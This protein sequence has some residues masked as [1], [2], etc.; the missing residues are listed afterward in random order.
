MQQRKPVI[1]I[2]GGVCS[3]KSTVANE[4]VKLGC[5]RIDADQIVHELLDDLSIKGKIV[6]SF[7]QQVLNSEGEIDRKKLAGIVF[8]NSQ[9]LEALNDI[10]HPLILARTKKLIEQYNQQPSNKAI[11]LDM[12]LLVEVGWEKRCD[13]LIFVKCDE[14]LRLDR[15]KKIGLC[16]E[17]QL[18]LRENFQI[19]LDSKT[20]LADNVIDNNS[21]FSML[22]R[23]V[24]GIFS[25]IM[26]K[27]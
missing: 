8:S 3:G 1:G 10:L 21:G 12:P 23:Q 24:V 27:G 7:G 18:K 15:A 5:A 4:F 2:M 9:K 22:V 17:K 13:W 20:A 19:S 14:L 6:A 25:R 16:D 26:D 11:V